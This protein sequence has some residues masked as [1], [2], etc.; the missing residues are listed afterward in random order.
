MH[1]ANGVTSVPNVVSCGIDPCRG[2]AGRHGSNAGLEEIGKYTSASL[3]NTPPPRTCVREP[4]HK[5][6]GV[7]THRQTLGIPSAIAPLRQLH[8]SPSSEECHKRCQSPV[9]MLEHMF[10]HFAGDWDRL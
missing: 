2:D 4:I 3:P 10:E 6:A 7:T 1:A 8:Q 9:D 5:D